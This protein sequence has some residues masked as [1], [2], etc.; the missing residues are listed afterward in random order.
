VTA[1]QDQQ[2]S[3]DFAILWAACAKKRG[4]TQAKRTFLKLRERDELPSVEVLIASLKRWQLTRE[5]TRE[6]RRWQPRLSSWL[7]NSGWEDEME[8]QEVR[9]VLA[10][11]EI[12]TAKAPKL[13]TKV[14]S[15][16]WDLLKA[17]LILYEYE[18]WNP[19]LDA[20]VPVS[21]TEDE[22]VL[23]ADG[24]GKV[25]AFEENYRALVDRLSAARWGELF[26]VVVISAG[27]AV[28]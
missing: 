7:N 25:I 15:Q 27:E 8:A 24:I 2:A 4:R 20:L 12:E 1:E 18:K 28:Q 9:R 19:M 10:L 21:E 3:A 6:G 14:E 13:Y 16:K 11:E 26:Q 17:A 5:W 23:L 22:L